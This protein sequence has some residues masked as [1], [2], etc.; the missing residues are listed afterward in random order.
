MRLNKKRITGSVRVLL[1]QKLFNELKTILQN[2]LNK[3]KKFI[4]L[5]IA[6]LAHCNFYGQEWKIIDDNDEYKLFMRDHSS[7]TAWIKWEYKQVQIEKTV[8]NIELRIKRSLTLYEFDC[9]NKMS[10]WRSKI[11]YDDKDDVV[12]SDDRGDSAIMTNVIP[13]SV[14]EFILL[15]FCNSKK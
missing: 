14:G 6:F 1:L 15:K 10:G 8:L 2:H 5:L 11:T 4:L 3:M 13:D 12:Q 9:E 7:N